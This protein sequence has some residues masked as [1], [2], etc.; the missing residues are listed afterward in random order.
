MEQ[1]DLIENA[2]ENIQP[3]KTGRNIEKLVKASNFH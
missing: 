3:C 2:K 1:M